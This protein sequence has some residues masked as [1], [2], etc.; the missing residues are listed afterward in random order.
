MP[1]IL[2]TLIFFF[3]INTSLVFAGGIQEKT[4]SSIHQLMGMDTINST[5]RVFNIQEASF[6]VE[7]LYKA[8]QHK[9]GEF[10]IEYVIDN[11]FQS[12]ADTWPSSLNCDEAKKK[13]KF[14]SS[15][16]FEKFI[17]KMINEMIKNEKN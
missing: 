1:Q 6:S 5:L 10:K 3:F 8:I 15:E 4:V 2:K 12:V 11:K 13:W 9:F 17:K 7:D 16:D 14:T